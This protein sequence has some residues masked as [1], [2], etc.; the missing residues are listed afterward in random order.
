M[1]YSLAVKRDEMKKLTNIATERED[2]LKKA[3]KILE[4]DAARFDAF[5]KENNIKTMDATKR[6]ALQ[7]LL[8]TTNSWL[9]VHSFVLVFF[10]RFIHCIRLL[11]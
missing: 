3:E 11:I 8:S 5:L 2:A 10:V 7:S 9:F 6:F 1:S 4:E